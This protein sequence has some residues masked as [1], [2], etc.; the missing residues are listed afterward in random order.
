M[1]NLFE[2]VFENR[3]FVG[4]AIE[5]QIQEEHQIIKECVQ[6]HHKVQQLLFHSQINIKVKPITIAKFEKDIILR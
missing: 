6:A 2:Q 5:P 1:N 4:I 3:I